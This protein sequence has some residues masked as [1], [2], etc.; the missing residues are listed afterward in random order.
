MAR[1][2]DAVKRMQQFPELAISELGVSNF[3]VE[4]RKEEILR[5]T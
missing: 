4:F 5:R 2:D 3:W 1:Y